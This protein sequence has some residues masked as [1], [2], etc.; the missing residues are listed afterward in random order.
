MKTTASASAKPAEPAPKPI[1]PVV[2]DINRPFWDA[3]RDKRLMVQRCTGCGELR[4][5]AAPVC[6]Q[7]LGTGY[8]WQELSG[9][10]EVFSFIVIHRGY[11]PWWAARVPYNVALIELE[12]GVRMFSNVIGVA[13]DAL[14]VGQK[15]KVAF[16]QRD[17]DLF[18]PVFE[19]DAR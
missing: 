2:S 6:P 19:P 7:C 17:D 1:K 10:G 18:V 12:E 11:H 4:Y 13:N 16:E 3:C 9:R 8:E 14:A 5:P 15:V